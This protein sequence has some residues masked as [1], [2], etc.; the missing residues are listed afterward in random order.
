MFLPSGWE[1]RVKRSLGR[2][3]TTT[4]AVL[5]LGHMPPF[6]SASAVVIDGDRILAVLDPIRGEPVLPGG[7]LKW[8]ETPPA[9]VTREVREE[10][11][12]QIQPGPLICVAAGDEVAGEPGIIR[13]IYQGVIVG[14]SLCS[15]DEG[16][17]VWLPVY[18]FDQTSLRD[19][20]IVRAWRQRHDVTTGR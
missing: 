4:A 7:H 5:T 16:E 19:A 11:G 18:E 12:Y 1:F 8:R 2:F 14:G 13:I 17:A 15:S 6:V 10:T 20:A 9:A 3:V